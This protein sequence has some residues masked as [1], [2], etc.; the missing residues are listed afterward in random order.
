MEMVLLWIIV[1]PVFLFF[2]WPILLMAFSK[3]ITKF[4][5]ENGNIVIKPGDKI[6]WTENNR[7]YKGFVESISGDTAIVALYK[8]PNNDRQRGLKI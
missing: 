6:V 8:S 5:D 7:E 2:I 4:R 1:V 3:P